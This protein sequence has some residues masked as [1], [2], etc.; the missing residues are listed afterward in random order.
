M[1]SIII[2]LLLASIFPI[3]TK[4]IIRSFGSYYF[5][6]FLGEMDEVQRGAFMVMSS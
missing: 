6:P 2:T 4:S 1:I 5:S 3:R